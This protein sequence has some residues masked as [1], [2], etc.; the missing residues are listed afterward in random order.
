MRTTYSSNQISL[1][2]KSTADKQTEKS[3]ST[4]ICDYTLS[5]MMDVQCIPGGTFDEVMKAIPVIPHIFHS[6]FR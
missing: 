4:L 2:K 1:L 6:A 5:I 3:M